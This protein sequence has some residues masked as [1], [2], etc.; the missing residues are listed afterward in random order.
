MNR[1]IVGYYGFYYGQQRYSSRI[2]VYAVIAEPERGDNMSARSARWT[3]VDVDPSDLALQTHLVQRYFAMIKNHEANR[4]QSGLKLNAPTTPSSQASGSGNTTWNVNIGEGIITVNGVAIEFDAQA[5][6][7]V[8]AGSLIT[9]FVD[10]TF[11]KVGLDVT[12]SNAGLDSDISNQVVAGAGFELVSDDAGDTTQTVTIYGTDATDTAQSEA[13]GVN[14]VVVVPSTKTWNS[15]HGAI[16]DAAPA[17][18]VTIRRPTAGATI[19]TLA[20]GTLTR[21]LYNPATTVNDASIIFYA[22]GASTAKLTIVGV[23]KAAVAAL[24]TVTLA[25][26]TEVQSTKAWDSITSLALGEVAA[27]RT[28]SA[29]GCFVN[30]VV[31][32]AGFEVVSDAAGDTTQTVTIYGTNASNVAQNEALT[33]NGV[34]PVPST[35]TWNSIHGIIIDA[36]P[37]GNVSMTRP[38]AGLLITMLNAACMFKGL[39]MMGPLA[40]NDTILATKAGGASTARLTFVGKNIAG[41]AQIETIQLNGTTLVNTSGSWSELTYVALGELANTVTI[42]STSSNKSVVAAIVAKNVSGTITIVPV[43]GTVADVG[44][45]VPPIDSVIQAAVGANN[46]WVKIGEVTL[47]RTGDTTVAESKN[48]LQRPILGVTTDSTFAE[49]TG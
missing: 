34:T 19:T 40:I 49:F 33:L 24:E 32:G 28:V 20:A 30:Q 9:G 29:E 48:S 7:Q 15:I 6:F 36:A 4:V 5:D 26:A 1:G 44:S 46:E 22:D 18:T 13:L 42:T 37:A 14:G 45:A 17:G 27:A 11:S 3:E 2:I 25:G 35:K 38:T 23:D 47:S 41:T 10:Q 43:K 21:G 16:I 31:A 39:Y 8:H 12:L